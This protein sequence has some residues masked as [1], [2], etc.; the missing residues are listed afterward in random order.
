MPLP[1]EREGD[2]L[3]R[4]PDIT[5][6]RRHYGWEPTISLREGLTRMIEYFRDHEPD[7]RVRA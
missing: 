2:P 6:I 5:L 7:L 4:R 3:Q 1:A